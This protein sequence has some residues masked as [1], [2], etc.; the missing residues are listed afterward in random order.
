MPHIKASYFKLLLFIP[1]LFIFF[2][3]TTKKRQ[4]NGLTMMNLKGKV[5]SVTYLNYKTNRKT[6]EIYKDSLTMK[7]IAKFDEKGNK[8]EEYS[9]KNGTDLIFQHTSKYDD[10]N[11]VIEETLTEPGFLHPSASDS[12]KTKEGSVL[13]KV[14]YENT[15]DAE[16]HITKLKVSQDGKPWYY[17][18]YKYDEKGNR[19][20]QK[21]YQPG[22]T[23]NKTENYKYD[24]KGNRIEQEWFNGQNE[25]AGKYVN[26]YNENS[27]LTET[28]FFNQQNKLDWKESKEYDEY[29]NKTKDIN[30][31]KDG[32]KTYETTIKYS[33]FDK[34]GNWQQCVYFNNENESESGVLRTIDYYPE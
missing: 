2:S 27:Q 1:I 7:S 10:R 26:A 21:H 34:T 12:G 18:T 22:D 15:Y 3:C 8:I 16:G 19:I 23:L 20:E 30:Y 6:G 28:T 13:V 11:N 14:T 4:E 31:G 25:M 32:K 29:G 24:E 17:D 33:D 9:Y 5:M